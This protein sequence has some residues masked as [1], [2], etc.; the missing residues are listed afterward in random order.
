MQQ[1]LR[2]QAIQ[3]F[4]SSVEAGHLPTPHWSTNGLRLT[5]VSTDPDTRECI[6]CRVPL[7]GDQKRLCSGHWDF[8]ILDESL[9]SYRDIANYAKKNMIGLY[10]LHKPYG[11]HWYPIFKGVIRCQVCGDRTILVESLQNADGQVLKSHVVCRDHA[12]FR[13][14]DLNHHTD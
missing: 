10:I 5:R 9:R 8:V 14:D 11:G 2:N 4:I 6:V 1:S 3:N 13:C 7:L 12:S